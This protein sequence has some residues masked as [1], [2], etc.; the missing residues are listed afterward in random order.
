MEYINSFF[1]DLTKIINK[2]TVVLYYDYRGLH[3][4]GKKEEYFPANKVTINPSYEWDEEAKKLNISHRELEVFALLMDGHDNR[5]IA[6]ILGIQY[7]S[8]KN[9]IFSLYKKLK[10]KNMAQAAKLLILGNFIKTELKGIDWY[11]YDKEKLIKHFKW[12]LDSKNSRVTESQRNETKKFLLD[13][14]L[15][16]E[17]YKDRLDELKDKEDQ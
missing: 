14:G 8:V 4:W 9:H 3:M 12:V 13:F 7:Q 5:E 2:S 10:A 17:V 6:Q 16:G 15:F 1:K 11:N